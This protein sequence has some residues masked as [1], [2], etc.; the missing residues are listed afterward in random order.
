MQTKHNRHK[1]VQRHHCTNQG[2]NPTKLLPVP[3][4]HIPKPKVWPW[5]PQ[6]LRYYQNYTSCISNTA[7]YEVLLRYRI[8]GYYSYVDDLLLVLDSHIINIHDV[9][10]DF[11]TATPTLRFTLEENDK[12]NFLDIIIRDID[13]IHFNIYRKPSHRHNHSSR[14]MTPK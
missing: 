10:Q 14:L 6:L 2:D 4:E 3:G 13:S 5:E 7:L 11:N 8:V 1:T 12:L 9:L